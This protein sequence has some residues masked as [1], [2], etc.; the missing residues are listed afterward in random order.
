M[1]RYGRLLLLPTLVAGLAF[2]GLFTIWKFRPTDTGPERA[3][4]EALEVRF[5]H[6]ENLLAGTLFRPGKP[7]PHPAVVLVLGSD[8]VDRTYGG[9][10]TALGKHFARHGF[11]CLAWDKPGV[12]QSTGDYQRQTLRDRAE[13]AVAAVRFLQ[14]RQDIRRDQI[15]I[16]GHSQGG[17][18]APVAASLSGTVAFVIEVAGWQGPAWQQDPVRVGAELRAAGF[19]EADVRRA[20]G[21]SKYR[22]RL[23]RG[24]GPYEELERAQNAVKTRRWFGSIHFCDKALFDAARRCVGFD[25]GPSWEKVHCPVLV[26]YGDRDTSS[27]P[28]GK[29][30]AIIRRGL[31]KAGNRDVTVKIF[32]NADHSLCRAE[33]G[34]KHAS[35]KRAG[36]TN[37]VPGYLETMTTWLAE[38]WAPSNES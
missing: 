38:R 2:L 34:R 3:A 23:I 8:R 31:K 33:A 22:M 28:P 17:M 18:V 5:R 6:G 37:F 30:V 15:G 11:A 24:K 10:G 20:V 12:G 19:P 9:V 29:L 32:R 13:E 4:V 1:L 35:R 7:G 36:G 21:F 27:G 26:L 16:W 25:N 14:G